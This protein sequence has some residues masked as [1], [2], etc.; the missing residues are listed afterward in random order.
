MTD[1][2]GQRPLGLNIDTLPDIEKELVKR[3][4]SRARTKNLAARFPE[5]HIRLKLEDFDF[6]MG[7]EE[8]DPLRPKNPGGYLAQ[9]IQ[10]NY[11]FPKGF[12]SSAELKR[13]RL[14]KESEWLRRKVN[15]EVPPLR[16]C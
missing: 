7:R 4:V 9:A 16:I 12:K 10:E 6:R 8:S 13:E 15:Q 3:G 14:E 1:T 2:D 5:E 11:A